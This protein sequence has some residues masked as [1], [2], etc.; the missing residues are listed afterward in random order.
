MPAIATSLRYSHILDI[1]LLSLYMNVGCHGMH[2][3]S[4][5]YVQLY[6]RLKLEVTAVRQFLFLRGVGREN[7]ERV[8]IAKAEKWK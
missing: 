1:C 3:S 2:F 6:K 5:G 7:R 8:A 4:Y